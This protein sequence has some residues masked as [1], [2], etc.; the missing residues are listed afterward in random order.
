VLNQPTNV[1]LLAK[2]GDVQR[3]KRIVFALDYPAYIYLKEHFPG[4][5]QIL[6]IQHNDYI[7]WGIL[8]L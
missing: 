1:R 3:V 7:Y 5:L 2:R 4:L 6:A 8:S